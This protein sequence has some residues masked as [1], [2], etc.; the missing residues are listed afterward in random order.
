MKDNKTTPVFLGIS[1]ILDCLLY[2]QIICSSSLWCQLKFLCQLHWQR[3]ANCTFLILA[4]YMYYSF[5][6][7]Y[8]F[9]F[10]LNVFLQKW[11]GQIKCVLKLVP[12]RS[13][14]STLQYLT[15]RRNHQNNM[16]SFPRQNLGKGKLSISS[17]GSHL[18][19]LG[20]TVEKQGDSSN[21]LGVRAMSQ[22]QEGALK[23]VQ[24]SLT[25]I[26]DLEIR[27]LLAQGKGLQT[28][29]ENSL[30]FPIYR[31]DRSKS[32]ILALLETIVGCLGR[33]DYKNH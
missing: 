20:G 29:V 32:Q 24:I 7:C 15:H 22:F 5:P 21:S 8:F 11:K 12:Y 14:I 31:T 13:L 6:N 9:F 2:A 18:H 3:C 17:T 26:K 28:M 30:V 4:A 33:C 23:I 27:S 1:T 19:Y 16:P 25:R 10:I